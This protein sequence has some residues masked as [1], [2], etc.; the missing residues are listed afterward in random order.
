MLSDG[1]TISSVGRRVKKGD[2][3]GRIIPSADQQHWTSLMLDYEKADSDRELAEKELDRIRNLVEK[4]LLPD[5]DLLNAE[6]RFNR[7]NAELKSAKSRKAQ[8]Y[9]VA[10]SSIALCASHNGVI[11]KIGFRHGALVE[12]GDIVFEIFSPQQ[13]VIKG[14]VFQSDIQSIKD[15]RHAF[16]KNRGE[17]VKIDHLDENILN[18]EIVFDSETMS[19]TLEIAMKNVHHFRVGESVSL[20]LGIGEEKK[21]ITVPLSSIVDI[22][23]KPYL[24]I[25]SG[26]EMFQQMAVTLGA[27]NG[28]RVA[29]I[30][31]VDNHDKIVVSGGFEIYASSLGSFIDPHAG[32]NH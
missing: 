19:A 31:G 25:Q 29:V 20:N 5:R 14:F 10:K 16:L 8:L 13:I 17:I 27:S 30:A 24:F 4:G 1:K 2:V 9:G 23:T 12:S 3:L 28:K 7:F 18:D 15:I 26:K 11:K 6:N 21:F 22:N 32:H